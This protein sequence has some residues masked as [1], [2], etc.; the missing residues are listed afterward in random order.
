[1]DEDFNDYTQIRHMDCGACSGTVKVALVDWRLK[2]SVPCPHCPDGR[3]DLA[4]ARAH[5]D[6]C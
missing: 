4:H 6:D 5:A 1:V 2:D 3:I